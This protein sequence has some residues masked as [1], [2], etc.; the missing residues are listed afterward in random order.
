M[1]ISISSKLVPQSGL[2]ATHEDLNGVGGYVA[3]ATGLTGSPT[4]TQIQ[5]SINQLI[6]STRRKVGQLVFD[7]STSK[8]FRC[9]SPASGTWA[10]AFAG[11]GNI[12]TA[13]LVTTGEL[14]QV[15]LSTL[16]VDSNLN[17]NL[18]IATTYD[19]SRS[20]AF[21]STPIAADANTGTPAQLI[22]LLNTAAIGG[23]P[24]DAS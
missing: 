12:D 6:P 2:G 7:S 20:E 14:E 17:T 11:D 9:T 3:L 21:I 10:E 23:T 5:G 15:V 24:S 8:Y 1:S 18:T 13:G 16:R 19:P 4:D 22:V